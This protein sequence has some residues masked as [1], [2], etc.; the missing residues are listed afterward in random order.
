MSP[1]HTLSQEFETWARDAP[2]CRETWNDDETDRL[3]R[4]CE[5]GDGLLVRLDQPGQRC[6]TQRELVRLYRETMAATRAAWITVHGE[7]IYRTLTDQFRQFLRIDELLAVA[8]TRFPGLVPTPQQLQNDA[9]QRLG[10]KTGHEL[11]LGLVLGQWLAAPAIGRHLMAAMRMPTPDASAL[12]RTFQSAGELDLGLVRLTRHGQQAHLTICNP[13]CLNAEDDAL[14]AAME[15]AVDVAL[16]DP[17]T[18]VCILRGDVMAHPKYQG[19][20]VFCSGVNLTKLYSGELRFLFY[21]V[22][23]LGL[24]SK[25]L[26]G[27]WGGDSVWADAPDQGIEKP[28][29]AAVDT[30]AIGGGCQLLLVCDHVVAASNAYMSLPA[31]AEGF[32]P[33]VANL[34]LPQYV[35]RRL[36]NRIIYQNLQVPA[37]SAAGRMLVDDVVDPADMDATVVRVAQE[38]N[39]SGVQ[40]IIS[41]RKA[42]RH[43]TEPVDQFRCYMAT[44]SRE[45]ARCMFGTEI[46]PNLER[47]WTERRK[48]R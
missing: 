43:A 21:I 7:P 1:L 31:L 44:F 47:F 30:H 26:R 35:G 39:R 46:V 45:Q 24:V 38:M 11:S 41:N 27:L 5:A 34:R 42:F 8:A 18:E 20:R 48:G 16:L 37:D 33:G 14:V 9:R 17:G 40:G 15:C 19:Q 3:R 36:A 2:S 28:W 6:A 25:M 23:E 10:D 32:I 4:W 29:I 12:L 13:D 22:R